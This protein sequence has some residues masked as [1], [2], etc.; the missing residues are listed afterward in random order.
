MKRDRETQ[1]G[2]FV[3]LSLALIAITIF[4]LGREKQVFA[5]KELFFT[6]F[7]DVKGLKEGAPIRLGGITIGRV[8]EIGFAEDLKDTA[9]YLTLE[10]NEEYLS[11]IRSDSKAS[12]ASQGLLGDRFLSISS[13]TTPQLIPP[14]GT[15]GSQ[16]TGD[17][18]DILNTAAQVAQNVASLSET[19]DTVIGDFNEHST[20]N[21]RETLANIKE[22]STALK[23]GDGLVHRLIFSKEDGDRMLDDVEAAF[24]SVKTILGEIEKGDGLLHNLVYE[25]ASADITENF[26][27]AANNLSQA[28]KT[29]T[30]VVTEVRDGDG[31]LHGIIYGDNKTSM[32][33]FSA[34]LGRILDSLEEATTSLARG[35]GTLGALLMDPTLYDNFVEVTDDAKRSF[36]LRSAIRSTLND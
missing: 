2:M 25:S 8:S 13:G 3:V 1:A 11:R 7:T 26:S 34:K 20:D 22:I 30:E 17:I 21:L 6:S 10:V 15:L 18:S 36:L 14:G 23:D 27:K 32:G 4:A 28:S 19:L 31:M 29:L 5:S 35:S 12:I 24:K 16:D 33:E 9:V